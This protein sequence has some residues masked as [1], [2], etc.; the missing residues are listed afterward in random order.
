MT[1]LQTLVSYS[2]IGVALVFC[3]L[4]A[5]R[6]GGVTFARFVTALTQWRPTRWTL[7]VAWLWLGWHLFARV[8][9]QG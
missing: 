5:H 8:D 9:S 1:R 2:V 7:V 6:R 4:L 3:E